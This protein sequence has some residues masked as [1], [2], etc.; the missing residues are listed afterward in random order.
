MRSK[1]AASY[2]T[3]NETDSRSFVMASLPNSRLCQQQ[4]P[5]FGKAAIA[6]HA[7]VV[8]AD[9]PSTSFGA[10]RQQKY[11]WRS[12]TTAPVGVSLPGPVVA[13]T[14]HTVTAGRGCGCGRLPD[15]EAK[16]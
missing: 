4:L 13:Y 9:A 1:D 7:V 3:A 14:A 2:A 15:H 11:G 16:A 6:S 12:N 10:S 8:R 5:H